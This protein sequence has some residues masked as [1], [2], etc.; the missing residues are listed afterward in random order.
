MYELQ[1]F[2]E[3][4][5]VRGT[6]IT[7]TILYSLAGSGFCVQVAAAAAFRK[8]RFPA[9]S[10]LPQAVPSPKQSF[11]HLFMGDKFARIVPLNVQQ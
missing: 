1:T 11:S 7:S 6:G 5:A 2:F 3:G 9:I 4:G 8:H 10:M